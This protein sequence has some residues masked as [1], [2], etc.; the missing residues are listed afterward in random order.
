M[1]GRDKNEVI[2]PSNEEIEEVI[3]MLDSKT[4]EGVSRIGVHRVE[5][6]REDFVREVHH[7]GR[8]DV[9]SP[10]ADGSVGNFG[11]D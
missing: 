6:E 4:Q 11:C 1:T 2:I 7:H 5:T 8:C 9:G 3:K 10:F